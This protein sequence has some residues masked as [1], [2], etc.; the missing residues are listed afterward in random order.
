MKKTIDLVKIIPQ[1]QD[2]EIFPGELVFG[3]AID[4][5][6][7]E[8]FLSEH[9]IS[10]SK[11]VKLKELKEEG[12]KLLV[13]F[14]VKKYSNFEAYSI[15]IN[16]GG[17]LIKAAHNAG[18]FYALQTLKQII[19]FKDGL[20]V[21]PFLTIEDYPQMSWRGVVEGFYGKPW[22]HEQ[23]MDQISFYSSLKM[24]AFIYAPKDD[25]YH[26]ENWRDPYPST[27]INRMKELVNQ[28]QAGYLDFIFAISPGLDL[29]FTGDGANEDFEAMIFKIESMYN[30][31]V[32]SFAIFYDD[33][34]DKSGRF[35][36]EYINNIYRTIKQKHPDVKPFITVPTEYDAMTM[37]K[38]DGLTDYT[39]SFS[40][41]LDK[42]IILLWT[43]D[44]VVSDKVDLK[45]YNYMQK[46][47]GHNIGL[48]W[49]YPVSD[50]YNQKL[51]L[52]PVVEIDTKLDNLN[53]FFA[54]PMEHAELSKIALA[55]SADL[56]WNLKA[57]NPIISWQRSIEL[58]YPELAHEVLVWAKHSS[59]MNASWSVGLEDA[60]DVQKRIKILWEAVD[61]LDFAMIEEANNRLRQSFQAM[62]D[63]SHRLLEK[64]D[65]K[66]ISEGR[67]S[68]EKLGTMGT[69]GFTALE[70]IMALVSGD[71]N[72]YNSKKAEVTHAYPELKKG[73]LLSEKV[74]LSFIEDALNYTLEP[75]AC[76]ESSQSVIRPKQVIQFKNKSTNNASS[77][78]WKIQGPKNFEFNEK[79]LELSLSQEGSYSVE[80]TVSNSHGESKDYRKNYIQVSNDLVDKLTNVMEDA[81]VS[82]SSSTNKDETPENV[83]VVNKTNKWCAVGNETH[84]L[85]IEFDNEKTISQII[86]YHAE[87]GHEP[88]GMN[89][90]RFTILGSLDGHDYHV[91]STVKGNT[92]SITKHNFAAQTI[93]YL[94]LKIDKATQGVENTARIYGIEV[95]GW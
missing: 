37:Q 41:S 47:Y 12:Q 42:E 30:L 39:R 24:N 88:F 52:G 40:R 81:F 50:Y 57:Y 61:K 84:Q 73:I 76:F 5:I 55:T 69:R 21:F 71:V 7:P 56:S 3:R 86:L 74:V 36:A 32:R 23:R 20:G 27:E 9:L 54:N 78:Y 44:H 92:D 63:S 60:M 59:Q 35:Q 68:L 85:N 45:R 79:D 94:K 31:G 33:I 43:G 93:K 22:S 72:L 13:K 87:Y 25:I 83:L 46:I 89:T 53:Y 67:E 15:L 66:S 64:L 75:R 19:T 34:H 28:S 48:W 38:E 17:L 11:I 2:L 91:L 77:Y 8:G 80:L 49:N 82:A 16:E 95:K 29:R 6:K 65:G 90:N 1:P 18:F 26:R 62:V 51:A 14:E 4:V 58:L 10:L 70:M